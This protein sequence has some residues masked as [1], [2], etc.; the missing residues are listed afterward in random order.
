MARSLLLPVLLALRAAAQTASPYTDEKSG[1][2]FNGYTHS[3]GYRLGIALPENPTTDLIAQVVAPITN[4]GGWA[5]FPFGSTM[6]GSLL[7][8]AWPHEGEIVSSFRL[9]TGYT[10]PP[11]TTGNF[12]MTTIPDGTYVNDTA[13]A[14]TFLC[15][16]CIGG[17]GLVLSDTA[18]VIG[19]AYSDDAISDP[20]SAGSELTYHNAGFGLFGLTVDDAKSADFATWAALATGGSSNSSASG[21]GTTPI[22]GGG[23]TNGTMSGNNTATVSDSTY[24]YIVCGAGAGGIVVADRL[25]ESGAS[26]LLLE[27]GGPSLAFTGNND[28]LSWN[29]SVTIYDVPGLDYYLSQAG[30]P[31]FC[32][33]TADQAGCLLGGGTM[34]NG[35]SHLCLLDTVN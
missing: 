25:A 1:I 10:S 9:A 5:G 29:S 11:T 2:T 33:D 8:V 20:S 34:V 16:N 6:V 18:N 12:S 22:S 4:D 24:D 21:N 7:V 23:P 32:T 13:F 19:W 26:V 35:R 31:A 30:N 17:D 3:S 14:Y 15:S 28:T 27:R